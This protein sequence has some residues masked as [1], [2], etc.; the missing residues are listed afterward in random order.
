MRLAL[1]RGKVSVGV[2]IHPI[3]PT[4]LYDAALSARIEEV[5]RLRR[6]EAVDFASRIFLLRNPNRTGIGTNAAISLTW[7]M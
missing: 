5:W 3:V 2:G 4:P 1:F 6:I 7:S